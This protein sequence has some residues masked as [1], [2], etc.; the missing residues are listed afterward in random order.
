[1]IAGGKIVYSYFLY[2]TEF[3]LHSESSEFMAKLK[4]KT[5]YLRNQSSS[6]KHGR[7]LRTRAAQNDGCH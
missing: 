5:L 4:K 3:R 6:L 2:V 1:M 7:S